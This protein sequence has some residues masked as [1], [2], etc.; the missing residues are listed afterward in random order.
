MASVT[1]GI[2]K[3]TV[4]LQ[5]RDRSGLAP[6]SLLIYVVEPVGLADLISLMQLEGVVNFFR[7]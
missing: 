1:S 7:K 6:D 5:R 4:P 3:R 2:Y